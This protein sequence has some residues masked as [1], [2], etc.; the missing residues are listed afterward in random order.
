MY[1]IEEREGYFRVMLMETEVMKLSK[2]HPQ[3]MTIL[4]VYEYMLTIDKIR[5]NDFMAGVV[6]GAS[7]VSML[8]G[9]PAYIP[10]GPN[11]PPT[12]DFNQGK[13]G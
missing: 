13:G 2:E 3:T 10:G 4:L 5:A 7:Y 11:D 1:E 9:L 6:Q 12:E 8:V